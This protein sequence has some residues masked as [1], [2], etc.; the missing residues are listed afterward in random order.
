[1]T[2]SLFMFIPFLKLLITEVD[3]GEVKRVEDILRAN[4]I[5]YRIKSSSPRGAFGRHYDSKTYQQIVMPLYIN[6]QRPTITFIIY[7]RK[8]DYNR[9]VSLI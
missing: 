8:K 3:P 7:V 6:A 9:A 4:D 2:Q 1:M 5:P